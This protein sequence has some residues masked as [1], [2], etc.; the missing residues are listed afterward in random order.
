[1]SR[2]EIA[3]KL[4]HAVMAALAVFV[5]QSRRGDAVCG[6]AAMEQVNERFADGGLFVKVVEIFG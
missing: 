2:P 5:P 1:M 3:E 6:L 4:V